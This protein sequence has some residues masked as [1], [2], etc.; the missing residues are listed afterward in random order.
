MGNMPQAGLDV[1]TP[2]TLNTAVVDVLEK[3][4]GRK[5]FGLPVS[6]VKYF[7]RMLAIAAFRSVQQNV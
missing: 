4:K 6:D 5:A 1:K 3:E 2:E 7:S